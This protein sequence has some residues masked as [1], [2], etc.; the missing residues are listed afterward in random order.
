V[1][2]CLCAQFLHTTDAT[3]SSIPFQVPVDADD[4]EIEERIL[5]HLA[6]AA[7]IRRSHRH[8][9][10]EG[11]RSRSAAHGHGHPQIL[12]F[13]TAAEATPGGSLSSHPPQEGDHEHA[14]AVIS[15]RPLPTVDSAE[16]TAEDTS[17][18]HT[19]SVNG[20]VGSHDR[21]FLQ[22]STVYIYL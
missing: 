3:V 14:S 13:P 16:E 20:P 11:R 4:A 1:M 17:V 18:N 12:F 15:S 6:A 21:Y 19:A 7:A 5:Q 2:A 9:R 8:A 22:N 10:R